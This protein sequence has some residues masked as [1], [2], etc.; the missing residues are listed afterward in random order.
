M[1]KSQ[2]LR[3]VSSLA[4]E[5]GSL[6]QTQES[7]LEEILTRSPVSIDQFSDRMDE[8]RVL[9]ELGRVQVKAVQ[10][11]WGVDFELVAPGQSPA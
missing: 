5:A 4:T 3:K 2:K 8:V 7:L 10:Y 9:V 6:T 1:E 11:P